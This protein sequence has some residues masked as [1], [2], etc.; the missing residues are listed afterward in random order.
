MPDYRRAKIPGG[1]Y[2]FTVV[3]FDRMPILDNDLSR[4]ILRSAFDNVKTQY[5]F[6]MEAFCLLPDHLHC[7]WSL[8]GQD[9][10][11]SKRWRA[12]KGHFAREYQRSGG[13]HGIQSVSR[14]R[15]GEA[16]VWQR[17]FW[18][19]A[20]RDDKDLHRHLDYI[21][22]NPVKH[23][24][25]R[26]AADWPWSSFEKY[27]EIGFYEKDWGR[28]VSELVGGLDSFGE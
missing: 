9:S 6:E 12:I 15:R 17:R 25:V 1:T 2:F 4:E 23:G 27:V 10:D 3:T 28:P 14:L 20:I 8:P 18:E 11:Y 13:L 19:H 26:A 7:V 24:L 16:A 22:Y 21:H 5:P